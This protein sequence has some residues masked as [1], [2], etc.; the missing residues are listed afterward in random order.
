MKESYTIW[1]LT[2]SSKDTDKKRVIH[3]Q[4]EN[5]EIVIGKGTN[6]IIKEFFE[7]FPS[8]YQIDM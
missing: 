5:I 6:E 3:L 1:Q 2:L 4:S 7:S 8:R